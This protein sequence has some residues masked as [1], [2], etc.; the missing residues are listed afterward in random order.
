MFFN[1]RNRNKTIRELR[2]KQGYTAKELAIKIK[3][4]TSLI[5]KIDN[6][7]LK[8]IPEPLKSKLLPSLKGNK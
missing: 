6:R 4:S 2:K 3:V 1:F 7:K 8:H 5:S